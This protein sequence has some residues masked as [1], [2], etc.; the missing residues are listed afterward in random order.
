MIEHWDYENALIFVVI[1]FII[2]YLIAYSWRKNKITKR[3]RELKL[4]KHLL[5]K[6]KV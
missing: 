4:K 5:E 3:H 6:Q 1:V 2:T